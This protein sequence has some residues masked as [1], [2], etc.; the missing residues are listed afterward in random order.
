MSTK[1]LHFILFD[2]I[3]EIINDYFSIVLNDIIIFIVLRNRYSNRRL[4]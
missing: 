4:A 3:N 2:K 1:I